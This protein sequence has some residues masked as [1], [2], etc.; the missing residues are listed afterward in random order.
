MAQQQQHKPGEK[1]MSASSPSEAPPT[2]RVGAAQESGWARPPSRMQ[3]ILWSG[4][5]RAVFIGVLSIFALS[6]IPWLYFTRNAKHDSHA[7]YM[8]RA[9]RAR[10]E[11]LST[12]PSTSS[13][14]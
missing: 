5:R 13:T 2:A 6:S 8:D 7:D 9:E 1:S 12:S 11:R 3:Q 10:R 4:D 14:S